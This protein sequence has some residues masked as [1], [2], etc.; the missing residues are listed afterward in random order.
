MDIQTWKE[1]NSQCRPYAHFDKRVPL[2]GVW[3]YISN[4]E[5]VSTHGFYPFIHYTKQFNKFSK[6]KGVVTKERELCYSAH[7]DRYIYQYYSFL[8]NEKYNEFVRS[9]GINMSAI[10]YRNDLH[11]N[12]IHFAKLAFDFIRSTQ[13]CYVIIGDYTHFFDNLDHKYL[14][15]MLCHLLGTSSL[16]ADYYAVY[17]NVTRYS[18]WEMDDILTLNSL[19]HNESGVAELNKKSQVMRYE[20]FKTHKKKYIGT[21]KSGYGVPQGSAIS[22]TLSNVY[23]LEFDKTIHTYVKQ[24]SGIYMRYSDDFILVFPSKAQ[25][26]FRKSLQY[27]QDTIAATPR[28]DL[29]Q[30][31]T[32]IYHYAQGLV[33]CC[34]EEFLN[35]IENG[36]NIIS[37]LGFTFDGCDVR[38]RDKTLS[39][40]YNRMY[41]KTKTIIDNNG[42]T[43]HGNRISATQLYEK[44]SIKGADIGNGNFITYARKAKRIFAD[45]EKV[46]QVLERHMGKIRKK[47][48]SIDE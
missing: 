7:I 38:I 9:Q 12:N 13:S 15:K 11:M 3:N 16:A 46:G 33:H 8:L 1:R 27:V 28:L 36:N 32:Q 40:Y 6:T 10:A 17:K 5:K 37:Y 22:S 26:D 2:K 30:E 20:E 39:K 41:R 42:V 31:K 48:N 35:D 18:M 23:M 34:N 21:N 45:D 47:L 4:A 25:E 19:P 44:Y 29:Q 24:H 14:K 43:K